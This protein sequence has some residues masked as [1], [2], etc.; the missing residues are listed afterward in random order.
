MWR[1]CFEVNVLAPM[2]WAQ[3]VLP[4]MRHHQRGRILNVSSVGAVVPLPSFGAYSASKSALDQLT[5]CL[6][7]E[8]AQDGITVLA[9]AP[10][11]HTDMSRRLY[12]D[13]AIPAPLRTRF[14]SML[15]DQ[16]DEMLQYTL[17]MF[18]FLVSGGADHHS[19]QHVGYHATGR[20]SIEELRPTVPSSTAQYRGNSTLER[21]RA[22]TRAHRTNQ[23]CPGAAAND[24]HRSHP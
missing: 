13:E 19:G 14:H 2:Q 7:A 10:A 17:D 6:A 9:F 1:R 24:A 15:L 16:G 12:E 21:C 18:R 5:A 22:R 4:S 8:V 3:A 23:R 20:H 11:A